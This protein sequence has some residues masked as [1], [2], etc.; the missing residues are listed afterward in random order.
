MKKPN[1]PFPLKER[2]R[3]LSEA[4][5]GTGG[6]APSVQYSQNWRATLRKPVS[7]LGECH[8]VPYPRESEEKYASRAACAVYENH[9]R[10]SCERFTAYLGRKSP[11]RAGA[12]NPLVV[13]LVDDADDCG[14]TLDVFWHHFALNV[15]ARGSMLLLLN[16][17]SDNSAASMADVVSGSKRVVPYLTP[18]FPEDVASFELDDKR[19]FVSIGINAFEDVNGELVEVVRMWD[20]AG[21]AVMRGDR[22]LREGVHPFGVCPVLSFTESGE[23]FPKVGKYAQIA[24]L[25]KR[26]YNARSEL[27]EIL[28]GQT[29][30]LLTLQVP[31]ETAAMFDPDKT[32][33]T[34]G[35]H[36]L[37][38]HQGDTPAFIAPDSGP[39][40]TYM[41][42]IEAMRLAIARISMESG[43]ESQ[44]TSTQVESGLSRRMRFESLNADLATFAHGLQDLE[45]RM[46]VMFHRALGLQ[47]RVQV[48]FPS[49]FN[50]TDSAAELDTLLLM[51]QT[52]FP[53]AV[54]AEKR[55]TVVQAEF[56]RA[57]P[58]TLALLQ[59]SI[60]EQIQSV[61]AV[62]P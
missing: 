38:V 1:A 22:V 7:V 52:G 42:Q 13:R 46:W 19:R 43:T 35:V 28:R 15:K 49:D 33:A 39:A 8:L 4:L 47:N 53:E 58:G 54:L 9:L 56:D 62:A 48:T 55:R 27:D 57:E 59:A 60:D 50:L 44:G 3:F 26:L 20:A 14:T 6:F 17:P 37:L 30:S 41:A 12:D 23:A 45:A 24:D 25:S 61:T 36:S 21:W 34:I 29:F 5:D 31:A 11:A 32:A 51:Q 2:F 16:M 40:Q 18:V 10:T